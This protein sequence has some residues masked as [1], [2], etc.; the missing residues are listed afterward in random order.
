MGGVKKTWEREAREDMGVR[1][2]AKGAQ[3]SETKGLRT[4]CNNGVTDLPGVPGGY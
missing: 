2:W 3:L 4:F 1:R